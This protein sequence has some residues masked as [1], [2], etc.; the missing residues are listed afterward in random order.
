MQHLFAT[1]FEGEN[2]TLKKAGIRTSIP[3]QN[4]AMIWDEP[5]QRSRA[6]GPIYTSMGCCPMSR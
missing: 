1:I 6:K 3:I 2:A 4:Q 5:W